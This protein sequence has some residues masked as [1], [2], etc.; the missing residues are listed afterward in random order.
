VPAFNPV[1]SVAVIAVGLKEVTVN[2][3]VL[4]FTVGRTLPKPVP[5][6]AIV[7]VDRFG[8]ALVIEGGALSAKLANAKVTTATKENN[9]RYI[10]VFNV[11]DVPLPRGF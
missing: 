2:G 11:R 7:L 5:L 6:I 3:V 4:R 1:G 9:L 8:W 10:D